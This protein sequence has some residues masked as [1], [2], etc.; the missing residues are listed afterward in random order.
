MWSSCSPIF[1]WSIFNFSQ[2]SWVTFLHC[3]EGGWLEAHSLG[4]QQ[5][6]FLPC[7]TT[8]LKLA[9]AVDYHVI[10]LYCLCPAKLHLQDQ[11]QDLYVSLSCT[12]FCQFSVVLGDFYLWKQIAI[13]FQDFHPVLFLFHLFSFWCQLV[14]NLQL[15]GKLHQLSL[16]LTVWEWKHFSVPWNCHTMILNR[17]SLSEELFLS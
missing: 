13:L 15:T 14:G 6:E 11:F 16:H 10:I 4:A 3:E 8:A 7:W 5:L 12:M 9:K 2:V 17:I 1:H